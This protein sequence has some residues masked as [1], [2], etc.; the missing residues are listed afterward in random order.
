MI[1]IFLSDIFWTLFWFW[2]KQNQKTPRK[3]WQFKKKTYEN[4]QRSMGLTCNGFLPVLQNNEKSFRQTQK[5]R[6]IFRQTFSYAHYQIS[7]FYWFQFTCMTRYDIWMFFNEWTHYFIFNTRINP[8]LINCLIVSSN[9]I[10]E[11]TPKII[12]A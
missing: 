9:N 8:K 10:R 11:K 2:Q 6:N 4:Q 5:L 1:F 3:K 12:R 7:L